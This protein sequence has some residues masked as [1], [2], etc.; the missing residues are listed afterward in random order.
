MLRSILAA[1][2]LAFLAAPQAHG[3]DE[4]PRIEVE[5]EGVEGPLLENVRALSSLHRLAASK[6]LNAEMVGRLAQ[7]APNE[8]RTALRPFGYYEPDVTTEFTEI[9]GSLACE[10]DDQAGNARHA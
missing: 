3:K 6:D 5:F 4:K 10:G 2:C 1:L 7:R 9:R 8:A